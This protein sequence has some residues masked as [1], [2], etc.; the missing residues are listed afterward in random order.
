MYMYMYMYMYFVDN[1]TKLSQ[2][3]RAPPLII[4]TINFFSYPAHEIIKF[5]DVVFLNL[6]T[7]QWKLTAAHYARYSHKLE[8]PETD[9]G[10]SVDFSKV[11]QF[12]WLLV[13]A[14]RV[15]T[16]SQLACDTY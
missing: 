10:I 14:S 3:L 8:S 7:Q 9:V 16:G 1:C 4:E 6:V 15:D 5:P 13:W 11:I 2:K 12:D